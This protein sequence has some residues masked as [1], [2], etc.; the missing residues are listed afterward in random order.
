MGINVT[1]VA[2]STDGA[3]LPLGF[4]YREPAASGDLGEKHWIYVYN[5]DSVDFA[6]GHIIMRDAGTT[7][8]DGVLT[9]GNADVPALRIIGVAQHAIAAGSYGFILRKGIGEVQKDAVA[10]AADVTLIASDVGTAQA[11]R[12]CIDSGGGTSDVFAFATE[13][14]AGTSGGEKIT[15]MI[16]CVG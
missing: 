2:S 11:G 15:C 5:D 12:A 13:A 8:Y 3:A 6:E 4:I 9:P 10:T 14:A 16:S 7:T 1:D